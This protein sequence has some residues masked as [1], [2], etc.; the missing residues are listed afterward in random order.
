MHNTVDFCYLKECVWLVS[1]DRGIFPGRMA[2]FH[3]KHPSG[4]GDIAV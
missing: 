3:E 2:K 4:S 1:V